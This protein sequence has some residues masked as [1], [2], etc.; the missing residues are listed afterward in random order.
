MSNSMKRRF[1]LSSSEL[2]QSITA[3]SF[4]HCVRFAFTFKLETILDSFCFETFPS[5]AFVGLI[6]LT[7]GELG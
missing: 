5:S 7:S 1:F 2:N 6:S 4:F 3:A